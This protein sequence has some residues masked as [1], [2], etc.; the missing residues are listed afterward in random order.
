M[1]L[2]YL[3]KNE[4][5]FEEIVQSGAKIELERLKSQ[6]EGELSGN[7]INQIFYQVRYYIVPKNEWDSI[8]CHLL[9]VDFP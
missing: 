2:F 3:I 6:L 9:P 5:G 8:N 1:D 7:K 4:N